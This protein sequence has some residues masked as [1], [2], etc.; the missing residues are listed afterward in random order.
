MTYNKFLFLST[1]CCIASSFSL[2]N[3]YCKPVSIARIRL[4]SSAFNN[5]QAIPKKYTC[6]SKE[7]YSPPLSWKRIPQQA[8]SFVIICEDPDAPRGT[9]VHWF[10]YN[11]PAN[12]SALPQNIREGEDISEVPGI[13]QGPNDFG[14]H[15]WNGPCPP[16]GTHRYIFRIYALDVKNLNKIPEK[17]LT[18]D[19]FLNMYGDNVLGYG[20][21]TGLYT[22]TGEEKAEIP[23]VASKKSEKKQPQPFQKKLSDVNTCGY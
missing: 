19:T 12:I 21:L 4:E 22:K 16:H 7:N 3:I 2:K 10:I 11:I 9:F 8:K 17:A 20:E 13:K 5:N 14:K 23:V 6:E 1:F 18:K 15:G